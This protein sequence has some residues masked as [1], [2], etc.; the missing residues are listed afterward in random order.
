[1]LTG[2]SHEAF[3]KISVDIFF[4]IAP[5]A[6]A[7]PMTTDRRVQPP[8]DQASTARRGLA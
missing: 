3:G 7:S 1:M 6:I 8:P 4:A 2:L 5:F